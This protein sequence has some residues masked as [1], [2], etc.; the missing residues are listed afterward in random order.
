MTFIICNNG[1]AVEQI[2]GVTARY[3]RYLDL[4]RE[5]PTDDWAICDGETGEVIDWNLCVD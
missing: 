1:Y 4:V 5:F 2:S 3:D